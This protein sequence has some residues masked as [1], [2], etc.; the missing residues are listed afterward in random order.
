MSTKLVT[1]N[2]IDTTTLTA[3]TSV[4]PNNDAMLDTLPLDNVKLVSKS[5]V[6]RSKNADTLS[7]TGVLLEAKNVDSFIIC[8]Y[9]F[10]EGTQYQLALYGDSDQ[11]FLLWSTGLQTITASN[12]GEDIYYGISYLPVYFTEMAVYSFKLTLINSTTNPLDYFQ[13]YRLC[14][15]NSESTSVGAALNHRLT[16]N[17]KSLQYRTE[18]GTL[19]TDTIKKNKQIEFNL[20]NILESERADLVRTLANV[21]K[22]DEFFISTFDSSCDSDKDK[23]YRGLVKL[24]R[25]PRYTE[26]AYGIYNTKILVEEV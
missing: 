22:Q 11:Q 9:N 26:Y 12:A 8:G 15:G 3:N 23:A 25:V 19:R 17:D 4:N 5:L 10:T 14:F 21:G 24:I 2:Y 18:S 7:I 6:A 13:I 16:Y 20:N 1:R